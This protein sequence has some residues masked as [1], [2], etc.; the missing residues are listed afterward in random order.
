MGLK[1][2]SNRE[3]PNIMRGRKMLDILRGIEDQNNTKEQSQELK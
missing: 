3:I 1:E 2:E